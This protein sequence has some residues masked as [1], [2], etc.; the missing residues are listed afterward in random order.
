VTILKVLKDT[1]L[2][3]RKI[4]IPTYFPEWLQERIRNLRRPQVPKEKLGIGE[5]TDYDTDDDI[6]VIFEG[7]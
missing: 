5:C 7:P 6:Q 1:R 4:P 3:I 2:D